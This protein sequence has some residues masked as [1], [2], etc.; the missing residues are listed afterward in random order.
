MKTTA[1]QY[2]NEFVSL[3]I[4]ALMIVAL[5]AGQSSSASDAKVT[6]GFEQPLEAQQVHIEVVGASMFGDPAPFPKGSARTASA[7]PE[8][9]AVVR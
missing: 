7:D 3:T 4:L 1:A 9:P 5:A 6:A 2:L 8:R